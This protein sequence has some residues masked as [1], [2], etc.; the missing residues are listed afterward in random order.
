MK[1]QCP[2]IPF[3][4]A[5]YPDARCIDGY[6]WDLDSC[7][8]PGG[9]LFSGGD[10]PCPFCNAEKYIEEKVQDYAEAWLFEHLT[11][12][13]D[14]TPE[15]HALGLSMGR[16]KLEKEIKSLHAEYGWTPEVAA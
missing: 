16:N 10:V 14:W 7:D 2:E 11:D 1:K 9:P 4:G 13:E 3:F 5:R 8:E 6:M 12:A 15:Q